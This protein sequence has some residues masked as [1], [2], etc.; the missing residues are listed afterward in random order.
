MVIKY[1]SNIAGTTANVLT[2]FP[3]KTLNDW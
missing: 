3:M 2:M 1:F